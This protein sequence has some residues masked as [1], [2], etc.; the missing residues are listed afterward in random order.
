MRLTIMAISAALLTACNQQPADNQAVANGPAPAAVNQAAPKPEVA[1]PEQETPLAEPKGPIDP[2]SD[3][4]A[5]QVVQH[6]GALIEQRR[7]GEAERLWRDAEFAKSF[8]AELR[9]YS[10]LH[11]EIGKL[12]EPEGAAG[13]IYLT[14]PA[15]FYG[16]D[17]S[18]KPFRRAAE[19]TLRRVNDVPGSTEEQR[20]WHIE[21]IDW[22]SA[23]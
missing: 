13:S 9:K 12:G 23:G 17:A 1:V 6:Y 15:T 7:F 5:G 16:K 2:K 3:A 20:H 14:E 19:I 11:L 21:H 22:K 8:S 10:E 4:A 18:G